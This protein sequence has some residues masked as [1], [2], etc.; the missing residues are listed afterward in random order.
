MEMRSLKLLAVAFFALIICEGCFEMSKSGDSRGL[1]KLSFPGVEA[2]KSSI[3]CSI[4]GT[5]RKGRPRPGSSETEASMTG[6]IRL[7]FN[8][9]S[10]QDCREKAMEYC[11]DHLQEGHT[12]ENF[13]MIYRGGSDSQTQKYDVLKTCAVERTR[14]TD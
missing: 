6:M 9:Q 12:L 2:N 13:A 11:Q 1:D 4:Y 7:R 8:V 5:L 10:L 3:F 14:V